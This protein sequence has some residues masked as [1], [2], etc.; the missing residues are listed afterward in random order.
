MSTSAE[1]YAMR[2]EVDGRLVAAHLPEDYHGRQGTYSNH[3]CRCAP[4]TTE[5]ARAEKDRQE[6][7]R[8]KKQMERYRKSW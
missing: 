1:R 3:G 7:R 5:H 8:M 4:C 6:R 2:V